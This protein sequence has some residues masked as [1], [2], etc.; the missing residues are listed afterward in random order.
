MERNKV[1]PESLVRFSEDLPRSQPQEHHSYEPSGTSSRGVD[2]QATS[3]PPSVITKATVKKR[4]R[5][6]ARV[7]SIL[8]AVQI[9]TRQTRNDRKSDRAQ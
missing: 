6:K 8:T 5:I 4:T 7:Q 2:S 9:Q 1:Y 3:Y